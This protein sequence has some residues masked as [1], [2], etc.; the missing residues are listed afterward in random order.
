MSP[1]GKRESAPEVAR[2]GDIDPFSL[3]ELLSFH[4]PVGKAGRPATGRELKN[5][6]R[7]LSC[8]S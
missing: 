2:G 5:A 1:A 8:W 3:I 4:T 7:S 6:L